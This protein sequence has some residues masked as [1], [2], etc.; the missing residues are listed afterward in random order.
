MNQKID[1]LQLIA[2]DKSQISY[3]PR[4]NTFTGG[5]N[6]TILLQQVIYRW[7]QK[8]RHPFY[9]FSRPCKSS[10]Y[11]PGDSWEEELGM[12]RREF[13]SAR[14][15]VAAKTQ[16]NLTPTS[17]ISYWT[18]RYHRT[19]Y[20]ANE[21]LIIAELIKIYPEKSE[22]EVGIQ[23][24]LVMYESAITHDQPPQNE[25]LARAEFLSGSNQNTAQNDPS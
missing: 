7:V 2:D 18:D 5:V 4:W 1:L 13:E 19:W 25:N 17:L 15:K 16:G 23:G 9:K 6:A 22:A 3:R 11:R 8:N 10:Y 21:S 24:T 14:K 20:A 12:S